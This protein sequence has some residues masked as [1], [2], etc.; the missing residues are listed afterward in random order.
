MESNNNKVSAHLKE[1]FLKEF[2]WKMHHLK[3]N[4][5]KSSAADV[6]TSHRQLPTCWFNKFLKTLH[7]ARV[8]ARKCSNA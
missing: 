4:Y 7:A 2:T 1:K 6:T 8:I 3:P 5:V